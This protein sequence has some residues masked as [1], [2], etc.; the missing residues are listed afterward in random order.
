MAE[1]L[2]ELLPTFW[3][4]GPAAPFQREAMYPDQ[5]CD[6]YLRHGRPAL[7][8]VWRLPRGRWHAAAIRRFDRHFKDLRYRAIPSLWSGL[9]PQ[10]DYRYRR[11]RSGSEYIRRAR[12]P[13]DRTDWDAGPQVAAICPDEFAAWRAGSA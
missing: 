13:E 4:G 7:T 8:G 5:A 6:S 3:T 1:S 11:L 9:P 2:Y 10:D 12:D